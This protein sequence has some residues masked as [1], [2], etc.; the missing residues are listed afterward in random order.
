MFHELETS[1]R[2][3]LGLKPGSVS[4]Q[5]ISFDSDDYL[6]VYVELFPSTGTYFDRLEVQRIGSC[7]AN[8]TFEPPKLFGPYFFILL[9]YDFPGEELVSSLVAYSMS[10]FPSDH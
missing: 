1:L 5:N 4:L 3:K 9:P 10:F 7:I 8:Q 2:E 6:K